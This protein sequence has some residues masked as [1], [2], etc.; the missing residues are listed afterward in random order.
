MSPS[1]LN[2]V[3]DRNIEALHRR[4][5][6]DDSSRSIADQLAD[7]ISAFAGSMT[8]VYIHLAILAFWVLVNIGAITIVPKFDN[9]FVILA[10]ATSVEAIFLSTFILISQNRAALAADRRAEL[11]MHIGLLA[12]HEVTRLIQ[13]TT[14]IAEHLSI[15]IQKQDV[16]ELKKDVAPDSVLD[17]LES[18]ES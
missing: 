13:I 6:E 4:K 10:T 9:T 2:S 8:F 7:H 12:E 5:L 1:Q 16:E 17:K 3:L 11:D 15:E 14:A 18:A